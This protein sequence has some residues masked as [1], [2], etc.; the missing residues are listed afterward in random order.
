MPSTKVALVTGA[1]K[2]IGYEI[3]RQLGIAGVF[4]LLG[5]RNQAKGEEAART[6]QAHGIAVEPL[7][8]DVT[9]DESVARA[10]AFVEKQYGHLDILVNNAGIT[11]DR[12][13]KPSE[14]PVQDFA[15]SFDTNFFGPIRLLHAMIPL[16]RKSPAGRV[17]NM[18]SGKGSLAQHAAMD[19]EPHINTAPYNASKA[20]LNRVM[21][22][23]AKELKGT[24]IKINNVCPGF[25]STDLNGHAGVRSPEDGAK[26]AVKM[27]LL[28]EQG[29]T[30][31][32]QNDEGPVPW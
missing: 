3:A 10:A 26:I 8:L 25:V 21:L 30:G 28:T 23:Y 24:T 20:A 5:V 31:T 2:G 15:V 9:D 29:P 18:S 19:D 12:S 16:L 32:F 22:D 7:L 1:N 17:V 27:A 13:T 11:D 14:K 4:V 6:L